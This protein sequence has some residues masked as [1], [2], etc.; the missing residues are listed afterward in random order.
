MHAADELRFTAFLAAAA[1]AS[2][3][4]VRLPGVTGTASVSFLFVLAAIVNL[5]LPEALA[6]GALSMLVQSFWHARKR[7]R[8]VQLCFN[9]GSAAVA[10][11]GSA[12][13]YS[14]LL[15]HTSGLLALTAL[16]LA[17]YF[18]NTFAVAGIIALSETKPFLK[19]AA[20]YRWLLPYYTAGASFA[21]LI[22]RVPASIQWKIPIICLPIVYLVH[23]SYRNYVLQVEQDKKHFE[24][25]NSLHLQTIEALALAIDAKDHLTHDHLQRVQVYAVEIGKD[26]GLSTQ[27]LDALRAAAVLHDIGKL[28]V[29]ESIICKPGKLTRAEFEKMK[30][31]PVV[32]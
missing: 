1:I 12:L 27:D 7:P 31:H 32:G 4:K 15:N 22:G 17:Y 16:S 8:P 13:A 10:I 5:S 11:S 25:M 24:E 19:V 3:L 20:A 2:A 21:W 29:P 6:V 26:L 9:L 23:R 18:T 30:I 28:A 14:Y